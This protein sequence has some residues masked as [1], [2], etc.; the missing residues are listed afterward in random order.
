L[1]WAADAAALA[2][3]VIA[4]RVLHVIP[5]VSAL[6]GG[7]SRAIVDMERALTARGV[8]VTTA[9]TNNDGSE[10]L[11][12]PSGVPIT[13]P[14][15]T[16]WYFP[17]TSRLYK[18]SF[19]LAGWLRENIAHFDIVHTHALFS[20]TPVVAAL[21]ARRASV[22][23]ILR[24][25]GVLAPYGMT[26]RRAVLK[27]ISLAMVERGLIESASAVQ[28]TSRSELEETEKL[29]LR[30]KGV[31]IPLGIDVGLMANRTGR[32]GTPANFLFLS[33]ID[34]KK[35][36]E[37][38]LEAFARLAARYDNIAL[39]VAGGGDETYIRGLKTMADK[40]G[41]AGRV[42]WLGHVDGER[43]RHLLANAD[44]FILPSFSENFGIAVVEALAAG[45][46]CIVSSKVAVE[47]EIRR[48]GA[49]IVV[50]TDV[51]SI[52][53]GIEGVLAESHRQGEMSR[54]ARKLAAGSFSIEA[55][56]ARLEALYRGIAKAA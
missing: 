8:D 5:S 50:G 6:D 46:P 17:L 43:K 25:L 3:R 22:P 20:F 23:Y 10:T 24:P 11:D 14:Y 36:L 29:G 45:L 48:A 52:A 21:I 31:V 32:T 39:Q 2:H 26:K 42:Q 54:A 30:C 35:N 55:M 27:R 19:G 16:R 1:Q 38:L 53:S 41:L 28:F 18:F 51:A 7:P 4:I 49:G 13:T 15:A 47:D 56:G 9:T 12:V 34:P 33:R 44:V 40:S 37:S